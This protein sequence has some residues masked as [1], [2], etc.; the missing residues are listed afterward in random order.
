MKT[1]R[2]CGKTKPLTDFYKHERMADGHLNKCKTCVKARVTAHREANIERIRAYDSVRAKNKGR[3]AEASRLSAAWRAA[4]RRRVRCHSAVARAIRSGRLVAKPCSQC[5][6][7]KAVA[8]HDDY[9]KPLAVVWLCQ[10]CHSKAHRLI[11]QGTT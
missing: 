11:N 7:K 10:P 9:N 8:H 2:E 3:M 6:E 4:D 1:C 5:G